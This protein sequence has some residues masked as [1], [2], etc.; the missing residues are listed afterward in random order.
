MGL[1]GRNRKRVGSDPQ[2]FTI[3]VT[4]VNDAPI[5][6]PV[7]LAP[8]AEDSGVRLITQAELLANASDT[9]G[10]SLVSAT[11]TN[12]S[13]AGGTLTH[14]GGT[15]VSSG[16][17]LTVA[18]LDTLVYTPPTNTIGTPLA[19]FDFTVNDSGAGVTA[20]QMSINVSAVNDVPMATA[21]TVSTNEDVHS[22]LISG[23]RHFASRK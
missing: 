6:A 4:P 23:L 12:L 16:D 15:T 22:S 5:T 7:T 1:P 20:A 14:S 17:T 21:N 2:T 18:Q 9:E 3:T 8:I 13:L 11:I 19:G 10:D